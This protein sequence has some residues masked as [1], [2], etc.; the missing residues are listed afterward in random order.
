MPDQART[1]VRLDEPAQSGGKRLAAGGRDVAPRNR[2][3]V[4]P[5]QNRVFQAGAEPREVA[6]GAHQ[7]AG[8]GDARGRDRGRRG[9]ALPGAIG[10]RAAAEDGLI[11]RVRP[12]REHALGHGGPAGQV[13]AGDGIT[14]R[15][16]VEHGGCQALAKRRAETALRRCGER[17][18]AR[19]VVLER[20]AG[21]CVG[22]VR[23]HLADRCCWH[24]QPAGETAHGAVE[25]H[26]E[27]RAPQHERR[28]HRLGQIADE[29]RRVWRGTNGCV[30][31]GESVARFPDDPAVPGDGRGQPG[32]AGLLAQ[33]IQV[34]AEEGE[35]VIE[36]VGPGLWLLGAARAGRQGQ[37][38]CRD[39][40]RQAPGSHGK[41]PCPPRRG[42]EEHRW[43][44]LTTGRAPS[45]TVTA[46]GSRLRAQGFSKTGA[47]LISPAGRSGR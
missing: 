40:G 14:H 5:H 36:A 26:P 10:L 46:Q 1:V 28:R 3:R 47:R 9:P 39:E 37:Q 17:G 35:D 42:R 12:V 13:G 33:R 41:G 15:Q 7:P 6:H 25:I 18:E 8:R 2:Q 24:R 20:L 22:G 4:L 19:G 29:I 30:D 11:T 21:R 23:Q 38:A 45:C 31:V 44:H 43:A 34:L 32:D 16:P 27:L